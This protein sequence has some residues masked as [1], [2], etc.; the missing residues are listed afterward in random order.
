MYLFQ[1]LGGEIPL[2]PCEIPLIIIDGETQKT[3]LEF[4]I[5]GK[6]RPGCGR[7]YSNAFIISEEY[8]NLIA[9]FYHIERFIPGF[10][11]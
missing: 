1:I 9:A 8:V 11:S 4:K 3:F 10:Y 7:R 2:Q 6:N 5:S